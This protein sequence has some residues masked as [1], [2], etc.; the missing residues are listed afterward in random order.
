MLDAPETPAMT[1]ASMETERLA[2]IVG[3]NIRKQRKARGWSMDKLA[4][5][6]GTTQ[7]TIQRLE[8]ATMTLSVDWVERVCSA[9]EISPHV[10]FSHPP[11]VEME[12][13]ERE[14]E[15]FRAEVRVFRERIDRFLELT[16]KGG[17]Q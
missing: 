10:L 3:I 17:K 1:E 5:F 7:Q 13:R 14:M 15:D 16:E 6:C 4:G 8:L 12:R 9:F 2:K 11:E